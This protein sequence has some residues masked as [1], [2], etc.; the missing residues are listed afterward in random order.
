MFV[1]R[2]VLLWTVTILTYLKS[3]TLATIPKPETVLVPVPFDQL[4]NIQ[5]SSGPGLMESTCGTYRPYSG[6]MINKVIKCHKTSIGVRGAGSR[7]GGE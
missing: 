3:F 5:W 2:R 6:T 1:T 7:G 4:G